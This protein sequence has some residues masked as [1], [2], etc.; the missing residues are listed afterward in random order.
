MQP[1]VPH[2]PSTRPENKPHRFAA[3][4]FHRGAFDK[5]G[6]PMGTS[7]LGYIGTIPMSGSSGPIEGKYEVIAKIREGGMG[8]IYKVRHRLLNELRVIKVMRPEVAESADQRKRFLREAQTATRLKHENVVSFYDFFVDD[9]GTAYMVMEYIEGI[10]VRDMIRQCG[11]LPVDLALFLSKQCLSA[12][13]YLHRKGIVHRDIAPDNIMM[14]QE[15][16]GTLH[17]KL[18]DL[19]IAKLARAEEQEQ[20]TAAD[21]FIGKLRYSSPEQLTKRASSSQIDGR[22]DLFSYGVVLY[23]SLTGVCPYG[24]GSLQ[25]ILQHR[26]HKPPFA[27]TE[28]DPKAR[29]GPALRGAILRALEKRP[30]DRYQDALAFAGALAAIPADDSPPEDPAR[31]KAYAENA[32]DI[33]RRAAAAAVPVGAGVEATLQSKFRS[34]EVSNRPVEATDREAKRQGVSY[35]GRPGPASSP[36]VPQPDDKTLAYAGPQGAKGTADLAKPAQEAVRKASTPLGGYVMV[37]VGAALVVAIAVVM[38]IV[39]TNKNHSGQVVPAPTA[40][41]LPPTSAPPVPTAAPAMQVPTAQA[42]PT[43][44]PPERPTA[45]ARRREDKRD[46]KNSGGRH[47]VALKQ[48]TAVVAPTRNRPRIH[49][50]HETGRTAFIQGVSK[51]IPK[52][53]ADPALAPARLDAGRIKINITVSPEEPVENQDFTVVAKLVNG[54]DGTLRLSSI[55]ESAATARGG[56]QPISG[57]TLPLSVDEG[58]V[59]ELYRTSRS[60]GA[61]ETYRKAFRVVEIKKGDAWENAINVKPCLEQ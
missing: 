32:I 27:F 40:I 30:E 15:E 5:R 20:L 26:L 47:D 60:L 37:A 48:T 33:A 49:F 19:G 59:L 18:I 42:V 29:V 53:F 2:D 16:D 31:V 58:G 36:R 43:E 38:S 7:A 23:E 54:G 45:A 6:Y 24:G 11:P 34:S 28:T 22:S 35:G 3:I 21:E 12:L 61:G 52:G 14:M 8:A 56:F 13:A 55:E 57:F 41:P 50:C 10:N 51:D 17:A 9:E 1:R 46:E 44:L 39:V 4:V 25:D